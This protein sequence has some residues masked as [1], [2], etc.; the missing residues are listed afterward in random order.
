MGWAHRTAT[1][2]HSFLTLV[3]TTQFYIKFFIY[4]AERSYFPKFPNIYWKRVE[5]VISGNI[6]T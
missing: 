3:T 1:V 4:S 5:Y 2:A 6:G